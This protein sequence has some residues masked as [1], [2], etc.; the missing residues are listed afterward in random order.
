MKEKRDTHAQGR[1]STVCGRPLQGALLA[2][3]SAPPTC[4]TCLVRLGKR[5]K[6]KP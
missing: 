6:V 2:S 5:L 1:T 4:R 3:E